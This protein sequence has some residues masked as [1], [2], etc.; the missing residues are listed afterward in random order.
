MQTVRY[1]GLD[2]AWHEV[3]PL[4][5][6]SV[7]KRA[8]NM[9]CA[10]FDELQAR[11][12]KECIDLALRVLAS[13]PFYLRKDSI[14]WLM[15]Y[16]SHLGDSIRDGRICVGTM[17]NCNLTDMLYTAGAGHD[18]FMFLTRIVGAISFVMEACFVGAHW[19]TVGSKAVYYSVDPLFG[20]SAFD[21]PDVAR[22][23]HTYERL[24]TKRE[25]AWMSKLYADQT[26]LLFQIPPG[27]QMIVSLPEGDWIVIEGA[28]FAGVVQRFHLSSAPAKRAIRGRC[29]APVCE[30][31][32]L[33]P[34]H[35]RHDV[36]IDY[37][38]PCLAPN[39]I[40]TTTALVSIPHE[41]II[42]PGE[43]NGD[44]SALDAELA[45]VM[46][47]RRVFP[48]KSGETR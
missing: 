26:P 10:E 23:K 48:L 42:G 6:Y 11:S 46:A 2:G 44:T 20:D 27:E 21:L 8:E 17:T 38:N 30:R 37:R 1:Q 40:F 43:I 28:R 39:T 3:E 12:F 31:P 36:M 19:K 34:F 7:V 24:H 9:V 45:R 22:L 29:H 35:V 4:P 14:P 47:H 13:E 32:E 25:K 41:W 5:A 15:T 18:R 16:V 33:T